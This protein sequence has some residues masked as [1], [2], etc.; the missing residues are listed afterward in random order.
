[1]TPNI[2]Y[3]IVIVLSIWVSP[4]YSVAYCALRDPVDKI[5]K[6]FPEATTYRS[7]VHEI[8]GTVQQQVKSQMS[9]SIHQNELGQHT[10]YIAMDEQRALG[11]VHARSEVGLWGLVEIVW[12]LDFDMNVL[13]FMFQRCRE[14]ACK[15]LSDVSFR[16]IIQN[17]SVPEL[18]ILLKQDTTFNSPS[19]TDDEDAKA[20][21]ETIIRSAIKTVLVTQYSW[22]DQ[23]QEYMKTMPE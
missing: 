10:L 21:V 3:I 17:K 2:K 20:L 5:Y 4:A 23:L 8:D 16:Q 22:H 14:R 7:I 18:A 1:M 12:A 19:I 6:L 11:I 9:F 15:Q 13:D